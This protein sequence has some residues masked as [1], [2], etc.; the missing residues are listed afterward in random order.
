MFLSVPWCPLRSFDAVFW[1]LTDFFR[2]L[3][4]W[5]GFVCIGLASGFDL[6]R[7]LL[8]LCDPLYKTKILN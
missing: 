6:C 7:L 5:L 3:P 8:T 1:T 2:F 4:V